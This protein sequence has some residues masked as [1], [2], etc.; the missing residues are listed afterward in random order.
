[1]IKIEENSG[2]WDEFNGVFDFFCTHFLWKLWTLSEVREKIHFTSPPPIKSV[3]TVMWGCHSYALGVYANKE[4]LKR[5]TLGRISLFSEYN[6]LGRS[7][8][9]VWEISVKNLQETLQS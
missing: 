7:E 3:N 2:K 6:E 5:E 9:T 4:F 8:T 1:M